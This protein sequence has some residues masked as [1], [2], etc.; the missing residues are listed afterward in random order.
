MNA[1]SNNANRTSMRNS[2]PV[3]MAPPLPARGQPGRAGDFGERLRSAASQYGAFAGVLPHL[4]AG[5]PPPGQP[6]SAPALALPRKR[7]PGTRYP[8]PEP[9]SFDAAATRQVPLLQVA[10]T[11]VVRQSEFACNAM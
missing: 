5:P 9:C 1:A 7:A 3:T 6:P 11:L 8:Q 10:A 4:S 2:T